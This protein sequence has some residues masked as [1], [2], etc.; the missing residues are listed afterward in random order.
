M[1]LSSVSRRTFFGSIVAGSAAFHVLQAKSSAAPT[2]N[3]TKD[4]EAIRAVDTH[5]H[6]FNVFYLPILGILVSLVE[7]KEIDRKVAVAAAKILTLIGFDRQYRLVEDRDTIQKILNDDY[8][9]T[10]A[11]LFAETPPEAFGDGDVL[12]G[13]A[14]VEGLPGLIGDAIYTPKERFRDGFKKV[15]NL[16]A[17]ARPVE[18]F[19]EARAFL[20]WLRLMTRDERAILD[21]YRHTYPEA[22]LIVA[23]LMDMEKYYPGEAHYPVAEQVRRMRLLMNYSEGR[24][25]F[26]VGYN[27]QR[28]PRLAEVRSA[29]RQGAAGV[30]FYPPNG[31]RPAGNTDSSIDA[32]NDALFDFCA[33]EQIPI[34]T[35]C[36]PIGFQAH[37]GTGAL[38]DPEYWR[39]VLEKKHRDL[40]LCFG[41][42]GGGS[43]WVQPSEPARRYRNTVLDYCNDLDNVYCELGYFEEILDPNGSKDLAEVLNQ[44]TSQRPKLKDKIM[45]GTDWHM[46][47]KLKD[48]ADY[49]ERF[50]KVFVAGPLSGFSRAFF[51]DNA[52][53]FLALD[54]FIKRQEK[55]ALP[56]G[57][58][59]ARAIQR[60]RGLIQ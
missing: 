4:S 31:Y 57:V 47:H 25:L 38:S 56:P 30:K 58:I 13:L 9:Q 39:P 7:Q 29:I 36:T 37:K 35:H 27:P 18:L 17:H 60:V 59:D 50:R 23:H 26:F 48:H 51:V 11:G 16:I 44:V 54:R 21:L 5:V 3:A 22:D 24:V 49:L 43:G 55:A 2:E 1:A 6:L 46:I 15:M 14:A 42:A 41:H 53:R 34:L 32:A 10:I 8:D 20:A 19:E 28:G 12:D 45:Y 52:L 33:A 40:R